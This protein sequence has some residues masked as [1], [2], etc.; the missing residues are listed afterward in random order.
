MELKTQIVTATLNMQATFTPD[1]YLGY[2]KAYDREPSQED[3]KDW[4]REE[5]M[6]YI[7]DYMHSDIDMK[8]QDA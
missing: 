3:F 1:E 4:V 2:C 5:F 7:N 6:E 8:L